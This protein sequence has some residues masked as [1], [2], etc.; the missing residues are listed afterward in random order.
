MKLR[1]FKIEKIR[2]IES[3]TDLKQF[4]N[5]VYLQEVK[6]A[7]NKMITQYEKNIEI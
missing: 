5:Y 7:A 1:K 2:R 4:C 6:T 3:V